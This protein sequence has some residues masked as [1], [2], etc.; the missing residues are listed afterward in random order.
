MLIAKAKE[1]ILSEKQKQIISELARSKH[2]PLHLII[3]AEIILRASQ[4]SN[5]SEILRAM[6]IDA[7]QVRRWRNRYFDNQEH[8]SRIERETPH[9]IRSAIINILSD[10]QRSGGPPKFKDDQVAA[11]I[12]MACES[13][14][15]FDLPVSHWTPGIKRKKAI[16]LGIVEEI[17]VRQVGRFLKGAGLAASP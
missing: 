10:T 5:N 2:Q 9:K 13:P 12:A 4:G 7:K 15:K 17:S 6:D 3:R 1:I 8:L 11:I 14:E 16:E